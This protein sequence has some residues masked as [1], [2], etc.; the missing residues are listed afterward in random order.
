MQNARSRRFRI[1][2]YRDSS[3]YLDVSEFVTESVLLGRSEPSYDLP[4]TSR[5]SFTV[6]K[7]SGLAESLDPKVNPRFAPGARVRIWIANSAGAWTAPPFGHETYISSPEY[8]PGVGANNAT[9][10]VEA[11]DALA[12]KI[13]IDGL[14]EPER[15]YDAQGNPVPTTRNVQGTTRTL[16]DL[17]NSF[18]SV[19][20]LGLLQGGAGW[21][22]AETNTYVVFLGTGADASLQQLNQMVWANPDEQR[23]Q[24]FL[25]CDNSGAVRPARVR[26]DMSVVQ[27]ANRLFSATWGQFS[28]LFDYGPDSRGRGQLPEKVRVYGTGKVARERESRI[29]R[30]GGGSPTPGFSLGKPFPSI[31][32]WTSEEN[33]FWASKQITFSKTVYAS[34]AAVIPQ[35]GTSGG[36]G[37]FGYVQANREAYTENYD[38]R[39]RISQ[40]IEE[41]FLPPA[42]IKAGQSGSSAAIGS[43]PSYSKTTTYLYD[44]ADVLLEELVS[45]TGAPEAIGDDAATDL[46]GYANTSTSFAFRGGTAYS[47]TSAHASNPS[48]ALGLLPYG[49]SSSAADE[50]ANPG[51]TKFFPSR[52]YD[53]TYPVQHIE[54]IQWSGGLR[55]TGRTK[56]YDFG[57][58][59]LTGDRTAML[60]KNIARLEIAAFNKHFVEFELTDDLFSIW[61]TPGKVV[62]INEID[63]GVE[64]HYYSGNDAIE[65]TDVETKCRT[66]LY[67]IGSTI[68]GVT[69]NPY[70]SVQTQLLSSSGTAL[71]SSSGQPLFASP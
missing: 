15:Q 60:A 61:T 57:S 42:V 36:S 19:K 52:Y 67:W 21:L 10:Q 18:L 64:H 54:Q 31:E 25:Y 58:N 43:T 47:R 44:N 38:L 2:I 20:S 41:K 65:I 7:D 45:E 71:L 62:S 1:W 26:L 68:N 28:E 70:Q 63:N 11:I 6:A 35:S 29:V 22:S 23:L 33:I 30:S 5:V 53:H 66:S 50:K 4:C 8:D 17:V 49:E 27:A 46:V 69:A 55:V 9:L 51:N 12:Q 56:P 34:A 14:F 37:G 3:D 32:R 24:N 40:R 39:D 13:E 48:Y 59:I 16:R